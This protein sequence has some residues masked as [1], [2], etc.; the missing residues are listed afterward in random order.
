MKLTKGKLS[1]IY[2]KKKQT[3]R[4]FKKKGKKSIRRKSFRKRRPL[5]LNHKTLKNIEQIQMMTMTGGDYQPPSPSI[6][7]AH[8]TVIDSSKQMQEQLAKLV[9][10][11][12]SGSDNGSESNLTAPLLEE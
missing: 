3:M 8:S 7:V 12:N 11:R 2:N 6:P 1:K 5:N 4:K 10:R 9:E